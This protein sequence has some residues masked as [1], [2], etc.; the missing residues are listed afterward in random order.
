MLTVAEVRQATATARRVARLSRGLVEVEDVQQELLTWMWENLEKVTAWR[1]EDRGGLLQ[2][3]LYRRGLSYVDRERLQRT[4][5]KS[6]D[7]TY[8]T[9]AMIREGLE[10]VFD[11][12]SWL[13]VNDPT[14]DRG[15]SRPSEGNNR[16]AMLCDVSSA[17]ASLPEE[18]QKRLRIVFQAM[19]PYEVLAVH[20]ETTEDGARK[21]IDRLISKLV[22]RLGGPPPWFTPSRVIRSNASAVAEVNNEA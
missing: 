13:P 21:R 14:N 4:G 15:Q 8:Y 16:L 17:V 7:L 12:E 19:V 5:S 18:D 22:D 2:T 9:P 11:P 1:E 3:V 6:G 10:Q 20:W